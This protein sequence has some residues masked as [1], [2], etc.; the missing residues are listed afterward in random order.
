M[1][2]DH[3]QATV[4][5]H[6]EAAML[7]PR[8]STRCVRIL[9]SRS[10]HTV[11]PGIRIPPKRRSE[12][13]KRAASTAR[14]RQR[15]RPTRRLSIHEDATPR[16]NPLLHCSC[17][18][19]EQTCPSV[20][21]AGTLHRSDPPDQPALRCCSSGPQLRIAP[22]QSAQQEETTRQARGLLPVQKPPTEPWLHVRP[23]RLRLCG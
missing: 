17:D 4:S 2:S 7:A 5:H 15:G 11:P 9:A 14:I 13:G 20:R 1:L 18:G 6:G 21:V 12:A 8:S 16:R 19:C 22:V 10:R 23:R 3:R